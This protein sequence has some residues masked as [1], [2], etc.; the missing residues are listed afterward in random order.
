MIFS[1]K[2][3]GLVILGCIGFFQQSGINIKKDIQTYF[4]FS[5]IFVVVQIAVCDVERKLEFV[6]TINVVRS[7]VTATIRMS[8]AL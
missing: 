4:I 1:T 8:I 2:F 5:H 3:T 7:T 6:R